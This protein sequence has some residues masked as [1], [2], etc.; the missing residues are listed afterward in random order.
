MIKL[1]LFIQLLGLG[2]NPGNGNPSQIISC[3]YTNTELSVFCQKIEAQTGVAIYYQEAWIKD[4]KVNIENDSISVIN[5]FRF[6][7][8]S[9]DLKVIVWNDNIIISPKT[10]IRH[11]PNYSFLQ[12]KTSKKEDVQQFL[13]TQSAT[14]YKEL[15][16][17]KKQKTNLKQKNRLQIR[18]VD[19]RTG[20]TLTGATLYIP[21]L[22]KGTVSDI[23]GNLSIFLYPGIY[24]I[25]F[26]FMGYKK[27]KYKLHMNSSGKAIVKLDK[28]GF[29]IDEINIYADKLVE[30]EPGV[31]KIRT[32][33][34]KKLPTL[35]G[36]V[37]ILKV[38]E[39]LPGIVSVG[40]GSSGVYVRGGSADQNAFYINKIPI[41]NTSH[42]FGFSSAFNPDIIKNFSIYKGY[43]PL[44][45]GGR[46]SSVF[47]ISTRSGN[48]DHFTAHGGISPIAAN[49][50]IEAPI[51]KDTSSFL[52][53]GRSSYSDWLLKKIKNRDI[54]NSHAHFY[55][56]TAQY[57]YGVRKKQF[58]VFYYQSKDFF[59]Y[60]DKAEYQYQNNGLSINMNYQLSEKLRAEFSLA[61]SIYQFYSIDNSIPSTAYKQEYSINQNIFTGNFKHKITDKHQ[62]NY[63]VNIN[64]THLNRGKIAPYFSQRKEINLGKEK[65]IENALYLSD[66][67]KITPW[68]NL[69]LGVRFSV[70]NPLGDKKIYLYKENQEKSIET[71]NDSIMYGKNKIINWN[72]YPEIRA[73]LHINTDKNGAIKLAFNQMHQNLFMLN[74]SVAIAPNSQWK[75][76]DYYLKPSTGNQI[77]LGI[78]RNFLNSKIESS[79]EIFYTQSKNFTDFKDGADF[80]NTA[81][82]ETSVLQ[83]QQHA[84]GVELMIKKRGKKLDG[85][86]SYT[87]SRSL[88]KVNGVKDWEKINN[89]R[90]YPANFD[91]P[92]SFNAVINYNIKKRLSTSAVVSYQSGKPMTFPTGVYYVNNSSYLDYSSRNEYRIPDYFRIDLSLKLEGNFKKNKFLHSS[93][94]LGVYNI[95]GRDNAY[96]VFFQSKNN[97]VTGFQYTVIGVPIA[98]LTWVFK[99]GNYDSI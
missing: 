40:E 54:S 9:T 91:I 71:I 72:Y 5:A 86:L 1:I 31:E 18:I 17:G 36:E 92:N 79:M 66:F 58:S 67:Y 77:S 64:F 78:F 49:L 97:I 83:G 84:Y 99:L 16:V 19:S 22:Q 38:A 53:S 25:Q 11:L 41:F 90:E 6:I 61:A 13:A 37:D 89:G 56:L 46:L 43:I 63:G 32:K 51:K 10:I 47:D 35:L 65:G 74:T 8:K 23:N 28:S 60:S 98:T 70:Y 69:N 94:V 80:L 15:W 48:K 88:I 59:A 24:A 96:S 73:S 76:A 52:I 62:L 57:D 75:L 44:K 30:R 27:K 85:W 26:E 3:H 29:E 87:F 42:L 81:L 68:L 50:A 33:V 12:E 39:L 21:K 14:K 2:N 93:F 55:D 95:T 82:V 7:L 34:I 20:E 4:F 45:F